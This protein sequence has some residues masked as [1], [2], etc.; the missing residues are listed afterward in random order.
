MKWIATGAR[1]LI[2]RLTGR[3]VALPFMT[4]IA[5][6]DTVDTNSFRKDADT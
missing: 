4:E 6:N 5:Q 2:E 3:L 1:C